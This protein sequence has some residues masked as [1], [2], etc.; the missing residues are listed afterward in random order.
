MIQVEGLTKF[1]GPNPAIIDVS[2]E[3]KE[4]EIVAFLGPNGAGKSTTMRILT[5]YLLPT[6]G[7]ATIAGCDVVEDSLEA[8]RHIGY[9]PENVAL[10]SE[11]RVYQYLHFFARLRGIRGKA[12]REAVD[13]VISLCGLEDRASS[14]IGTLS[15]GYRQRV[16]LAQALVH[17]PPVIILDEPTIGLDP[18]QIIQVRQLIKSLAGEHTVMLSTHILP[19]AQMT[20]ERVIIIHRGQIVAE[21]TPDALTAQIRRAETILLRVGGDTSGLDK[22]ILDMPRV[23]AVRRGDEPGVFYVDSEVGADVRADLARLIVERGL[24]LLEL[25]P[26]GMT[27][28]E[29]FRHLTTEEETAEVA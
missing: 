13:R 27:L 18:N 5:G 8:R 17:D 11:M 21:D 16:G 20:C 7:R 15:K 25:R 3:V 12:A 22:I 10:Y 28:E 2:F 1:Y 9:M 19:E 4:G 6:A 29:V 26:V 24:D 14:I 23:T